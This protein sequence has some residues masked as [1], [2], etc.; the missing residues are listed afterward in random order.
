MS[1]RERERE[2]ER[3]RQTERETEKDRLKERERRRERVILS[4]LLEDHKIGISI[5][6][7][8]FNNHFE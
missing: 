4:I 7:Y 2:R 3:D 8:I 6:Y 5:V 1:V